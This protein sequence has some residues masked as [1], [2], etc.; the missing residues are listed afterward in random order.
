MGRLVYWNPET[1][2]EEE[3]WTCPYCSADLHCDCVG[4]CCPAC[5]EVID[6]DDV[7]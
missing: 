1:D 4:E 6:E 2:A 7:P 5:G 3:C